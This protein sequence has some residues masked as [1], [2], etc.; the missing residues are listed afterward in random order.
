MNIISK[1]RALAFSAFA[2]GLFAQASDASADSSCKAQWPAVITQCQNNNQFFS[3]NVTGSGRV[4]SGKLHVTA[5]LV[6]GLNPAK[7]SALDSSGFPLPGCTVID[8]TADNSSVSV[9]CTGI[10][11]SFFLTQTP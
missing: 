5:N 10:V 4:A 1:G 6:A 2:C 8:K 3:E 11:T 9:D 7:A